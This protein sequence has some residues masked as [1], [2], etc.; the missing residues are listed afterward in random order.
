M[1]FYDRSDCLNPSPHIDE[2]GTRSGIFII[3]NAIPKDLI[4][5][6]QEGLKA[7]PE[8]PPVYDKG[9]ISWYTN[10]MAEGVPGTVDLWETISQIL[11][12]EWVIHPANNYLVVRPGDNGMFIHTDSPGKG[13]CHLLSQTDV[14]STCCELDYGVCTYFGEYEGGAIF[15][16][17]INPDGTIKQNGESGGPCFE[18]T[19]EVGDIVVHSAFNPYGHGVREV[20]SGL[21]Y[22]YSNFCLKAKDNPGTFYNYGTS[23]YYEQIGDKSPERIRNWM[24][25]LKANPQFSEDKVKMYQESGLEGEELAKTFFSDM[26]PEN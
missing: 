11:A 13:A 24:E 16:P 18:Y 8:K 14:W 9:L 4:E 26:A 7:L 20:T 15:Y 25:P 6:I 22:V 10:K 17:E 3:K 19:P 21:R 2:Y 12:P 23:E 1:A 5:K